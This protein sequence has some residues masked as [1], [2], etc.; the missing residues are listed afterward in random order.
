MEVNV[1]EAKKRSVSGGLGWGTEDQFRARLGLRIRNLFGG[2]RYLDFEGRYAK[3]DSR[4]SG[5]FTNPQIGGSYFDLIIASALYYREYP[6]FNDQTLSA[7]TRLERE[8]PWNIKAYAG[9]L[10]QFDKSSDIP[11]TVQALFA[12]PQGQTFR[13]SVAFLGFR[14]DTTDDV[15]Y[16]TT[17]GIFIVHGECAPTFFGS[18]PQFISARVE[19][20]RFFNLR[21]KEFI[22]GTRLALGLMEPIQNSHEIPLYRRFFTG[23]YNTVRGY[24]LFLLGPT[25]I[26]GNPVGGNAL[27]EAN[28]EL[29][30]PIYQDLK[31]VVF[32]DAGNVYPSIADLNP[33]NMYYGT[34]FGL[35]YKTP[36]GPLGID[37]AFPTRQIQQKQNSFQV[38]LTIGQSF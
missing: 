13:T 38:Y 2:G 8:L 20:R 25:D 32:A 17:G 19:G 14:Q 18:D 31:G 1:T 10:V 4:F 9:F 28:L 29:R 7:Q 36:V 26:A 35:R 34:G 30:F 12:E 37:I 23:G 21:E 22:L 16:P 5:T 3:I 15:L 24:R 6:S 11:G 33:G 27:L